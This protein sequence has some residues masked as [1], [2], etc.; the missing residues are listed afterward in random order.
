M[1]ELFEQV[2]PGRTDSVRGGLWFRRAALALFGV[3]VLL[4]LLNTFGQQPSDSQAAG[5]AAVLKLNAPEDVRGGLFFQS[6]VQIDVRRDIQFPRLV[7]DEG[8]F[9]GMQINSIEPQPSSES[10]RDGRVVLTY[11]KL[12]PGDLVKIWFQ[13]EADPTYPG[14]RSYRVELDDQDRAIATI[15]RNIRIWP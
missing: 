10:S 13:F 14:S 8:W 4:A 11:D 6:R 12:S 1:A 3:F 2:D 7:L 15:D 5:P 9:E